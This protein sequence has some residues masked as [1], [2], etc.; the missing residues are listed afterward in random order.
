ML[1]RN[2]VRIE[3]NTEL[4]PIT[5]IIRKIRNCIEFFKSINWN[6]DVIKP[7]SYDN[8]NHID[9]KMKEEKLISFYYFAK[10]LWN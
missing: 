6:I 8:W 5:N 7:D 4:I 10:S 2:N 9:R 1:A 3:T